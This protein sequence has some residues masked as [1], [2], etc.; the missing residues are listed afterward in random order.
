MEATLRAVD[1]DHSTRP[2]ER[3]RFATLPPVGGVDLV[4]LFLLRA[5]LPVGRP[6]DISTWVNPQIG[7][8]ALSDAAP[9]FPDAFFDYIRFDPEGI[10]EVAVE[11]A[12]LDRQVQERERIGPVNLVAESEL[13]E[14]EENRTASQ[15]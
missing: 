3:R 12:R 13:A 15:A 1:T 6:A 11:S 8:A 10:A 7:P 2:L 4:V 14:L 5:F 9:S